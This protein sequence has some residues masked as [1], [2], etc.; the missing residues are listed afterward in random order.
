MPIGYHVCS[1]CAIVPAGERYHGRGHGV[2]CIVLIHPEWDG[3]EQEQK[4][5]QQG[6]DTHDAAIR[7]AK[8]SAINIETAQNCRF[9]RDEK[10]DNRTG[11]D[12]QKI[13]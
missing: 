1:T 4:I 12:G 8:E 7:G 9:H 11:D 3:H 13:L 10:D 2:P 6:G 5:P